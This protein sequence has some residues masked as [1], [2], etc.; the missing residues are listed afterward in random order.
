MAGE[1]DFALLGLSASH[2]PLLSV[3]PLA[4]AW[5]RVVPLTRD[6]K[7][8]AY[9]GEVKKIFSPNINQVMHEKPKLEIVQIQFC[10]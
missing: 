2:F 5:K 6:R 7:G 4:A 9:F 10:Q 3:S 1:S 8:S